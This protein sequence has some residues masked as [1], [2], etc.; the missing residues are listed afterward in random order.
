MIILLLVAFLA[1]VVTILSPCILPL[2]PIV[3]SGGVS[4]GKSRPWGVVVGF[5]GSFTFFTLTLA[6][7]TR[8]LGISADILR[9]LAAAVMII[10]GI[11]LV[12]DKIQLWFERA[13]G[14]SAGMG[15]KGPAREDFRSGLILG[16]SLGLV[17]TPCVGPILATV[18]SLAILGKVGLDSTLIMFSYAVGTAIPMLLVMYG[19]R[20]L[21]DKQVWLK[22]HLRGIQR[23]F[24]ILVIL[25]GVAIFFRLDQSFQS[26]LLDIFPNWGN[27]LTSV[28]NI[29]GVKQSL[30]KIKS[31]SSDVQ[32]GEPLFTAQQSEVVAPDFT[33]GGT[34]INTP[35]PL[36]L[37]GNLKGKVVLVDFWT[38][39]CINCIRTLP[40]LRDWYN[41]YKDQ[42]FVIV[43]VHSPEFEFEKNTG[44][45]RKAIKDLNVPYPVVQ[46]NDFNI[47]RAY[48][49]NY[50]P[51][52]YLIS[53]DGRI[54]YT[55][56][57]EGAYNETEQAIIK[58]L[59][60][61]RT[62]TGPEPTVP[63]MSGQT[64]ETYLGYARGASYDVSLRNNE[65]YSY[66]YTSPPGPNGVTLGGAWKVTN[67]YIE[68]GEAGAFLELNFKASKVYLVMS[69]EGSSTALNLRVTLDG[70]DITS[71]MKTA[72]MKTLGLINVDRADKFD[73]IDLGNTFDRHLLRLTADKGV[74]MYA[75]TFG[76]M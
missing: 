47:W 49:N 24:G 52:H 69:N 32:Q 30:S 39:S 57:G 45:V 63:I 75:F 26:K 41:K 1:G 68:A 14:F 3:L 48:N 7:L 12:S 60:E 4:G 10:F 6:F 19:G 46:D 51:A 71:T 40:Y 36:S 15:Q 11:T 22:L 74:R 20:Q 67:E 9:W 8:L 35:E 2:L 33:G 59:G 62:V 27:G 17:W 31:G 38:Y 13:V 54:I 43:G 42:G 34:W 44:N 56:F 55:H 23:A 21:L 37:N 72:D 16:A 70:K 29:P 73:V 5:V 76:S 18:L 28:E 66:N 50:W 64:Q 65:M 61:T 25:T 53:K 58:A